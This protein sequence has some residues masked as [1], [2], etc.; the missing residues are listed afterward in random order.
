MNRCFSYFP[1]SSRSSNGI[2]GGTVTY[3]IREEMKSQNKVYLINNPEDPAKEQ[4]AALAKNI[5]IQDFRV[6]ILRGL[7]AI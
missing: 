5:S 2:E 3:K 4:R 1:E 6:F 7:L